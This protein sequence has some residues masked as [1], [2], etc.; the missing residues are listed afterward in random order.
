M[1]EFTCAKC[2]TVIR[3]SDE[4][5]GK[6]GKCLTCGRK[7]VVPVPEAAPWQLGS[8]A[9]VEAELEFAP[10][11]VGRPDPA[12][13][14]V[15]QSQVAQPKAVQ[16]EAARPDATGPAAVR[17]QVAQPEGGAALGIQLTPP[18]PEVVESQA[19]EPVV[20]Q[21]EADE[22]ENSPTLDALTSATRYHSAAKVGAAKVGAAKVGAAKAPARPKAASGF[23]VSRTEPLAGIAKGIILLAL[24]AAVGFYFGKRQAVLHPSADPAAPAGYSSGI[25]QAVSPSAEAPSSETPPDDKSRTTALT[26]ENFD[27]PTQ[28]KKPVNRRS[29]P[30]PTSV[31][32]TGWQFD[33]PN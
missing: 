4:L 9:F 28:S 2:S 15:T 22:P 6:K 3:V 32:S 14:Q 12:K 21:P 24:G 19:P 26:P 18:M 20:F 23:Q 25:S 30:D 16:P 29:T 27:T 11:E 1:I 7:C 33:I 10:P 31:P 17:P 8:N 5:A 13:S